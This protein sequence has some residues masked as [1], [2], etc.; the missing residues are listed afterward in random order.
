[1]RLGGGDHGV[2]RAL[3]VPGG[4]LV[5]RGV[6]APH[7][8]AGETCAQ[9]HPG[10]AERDAFFADVDFG[11]GV[12]AIGKVFAGRHIAVSFIARKK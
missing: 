6:A 4:V 7:M 12:M 1:M 2:A 3:E 11:R 10:V 8:A 5:L 9:M